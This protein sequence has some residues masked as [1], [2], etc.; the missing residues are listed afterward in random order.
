MKLV[1]FEVAGYKRFSDRA[2]I[3]LSEKLVAIVGPNEA[4]KTSLLRCMEHFNHRQP[5]V[6][7]GGSQELTRGAVIQSDATVATWTFAI[8]EA[9]REELA[10]IPEFST[11]RWY[12]LSKQVSGSA[13][14]DLTPRP[15]RDISM[16]KTAIEHLSEYL[17]EVLIS[18]RSERLVTL[19]QE[20]ITALSSD[21]ETLSNATL[22]AIRGVARSIVSDQKSNLSMALE[23]LEAAES[24]ETPMK[25]IGAALSKRKPKILF[26]SDADRDLKPAYDLEK[27]CLTETLT[28]RR[29]E[30]PVAL[31]NLTL[32][33]G[34]DIF[35]LYDTQSRK[36]RGRVK[37]LLS[38]AEEK[39]TALLLK[40]WSQ[41][42]LAL[43]LELDGSVLQILIQSDSGEYVRVVERSD[44]LRQFVALLMFMAKQTG[45]ETKPILLIDEAENR[46]HYDAQADLVQV[47]ARQQLSSKIIY[48]THSIGCLP[49]DLGSGVRMVAMEDPYSCVVNHFWD[50]RRPGFS[51]LLFSMGAQTLA[52]L[53]M[54]YALITEGAADMILLPAILKSA[55]QLECLGFQVVPG[56]S[57][58]TTPEIA[59]LDNE[60]ARTAY[61]TDSDTAGKS[62]R[63]K[64]V[65]AGVKENMIIALPE[66]DGRE[67]V[68]ED[69]VPVESYVAAVSME[70]R[71]S[72]CAEEIT[73]KDLSRPNRPSRLAAW[74]KARKVQVPSKRA[75]AYHL[76]EQRYE[77]PIVD[78]DVAEK[79]RVLYA[80]LTKALGLEN[81]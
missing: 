70:L 62:L 78:S 79:V 55:L 53:P 29:A 60:S 10:S 14:F 35:D 80:S 3:N 8:D 40:S 41:S 1:W 54:R 22:D 42:R 50:S 44:G 9:D 31:S 4:G 81:K 17:N 13:T 77:L 33:S 52:F 20:L 36:D 18:S 74:C 57:S 65:A 63:S 66:I 75:V 48:T 37:T 73:S 58:G 39:L 16:R 27:Y 68:I 49:E 19:I 12:S 21:V 32:A 11:V 59:I 56:L 69:F 34:L 43:S 76:V 5:F 51:P 2:K 28:L 45:T 30:V 61:L 38:R 64:I 23:Q 25:R 67:T 47:L 71:R 26:F 72:G 24:L 7:D 46:L 15:K 6:V